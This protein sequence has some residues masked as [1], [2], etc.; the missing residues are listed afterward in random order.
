[1]ADN[2]DGEHISSAD[3]MNIDDF[4]YYKGVISDYTK[5]IELEPDDAYS[6]KEDLQSII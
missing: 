3:N 6:L 1:M 4:P 5:A 2:Y